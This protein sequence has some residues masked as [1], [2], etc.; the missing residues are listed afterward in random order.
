MTTSLERPTKSKLADVL[1]EAEIKDGIIKHQSKDAAW[2]GVSRTKK[3]LVAKATLRTLIL[4]MMDNIQK[5]ESLNSQTNID[6]LN[7]ALA[8]TSDATQ[9]VNS[10]PVVPTALGLHL[11]VLKTAGLLTQAEVDA[12]T[13][14]LALCPRERREID[15]KEGIYDFFA[16]ELIENQDDIVRLSDGHC[17]SKV[18]M[19]EYVRTGPVNRETGLP[20]LP[21]SQ[22]QINDIDYEILGVVKP[23]SNQMRRARRNQNMESFEQLIF[24]DIQAW[25]AGTGR[26]R[27]DFAYFITDPAERIRLA[28][29]LRV[30]VSNL[31]APHN[32]D[33]SQ[34]SQPQPVTAQ[35]GI[36]TQPRPF[37][38]QAQV[39]L[40]ASKIASNQAQVP[41]T[42]SKI[43]SSQAQVPRTASKITSSIQAQVPRTASKIASNQ[44]QV[45][46]TASKIASNQPISTAS[47]TATKIAQPPQQPRTAQKFAR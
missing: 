1:S 33:A 11:S 20:N 22:Q 3:A 41:R 18:G 19:S 44:A 30:N 42:A 12:I 17:Y 38:A 43:T 9:A 7:A 8:K 45:P 37:T 16:L 27:E 29:A 28:A 10:A 5:Y 40:T 25:R 23:D 4:T 34:V 13:S 24:G 47:N 26:A 31:P 21:F 46:R 36:G 35:K 39:P 6:Y 15:G 32:A 14:Y 2:A